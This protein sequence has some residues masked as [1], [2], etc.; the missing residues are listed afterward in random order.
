MLVSGARSCGHACTDVARRVRGRTCLE[1]LGKMR[2]K[3]SEKELD[4]LLSMGLMWATDL[5]TGLSEE[6]ALA[7]HALY[8]MPRMRCS[9]VFTL[10]ARLQGNTQRRDLLLRKGGRAEG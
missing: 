5:K 2:S 7:A 6:C 1:A 9:V 8:C 10:N 3:E 4:W